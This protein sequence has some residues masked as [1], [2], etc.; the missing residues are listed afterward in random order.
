MVA[1]PD[2]RPPFI[3]SR[4]G[5]GRCCSVQLTCYSIELRPLLPPPL[6]LSSSERLRRLVVQQLSGN[7]DEVTA[8]T[9]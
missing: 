3:R 8:V 1:N 5:H 4:R 7:Y 9:A 2:T 6:L